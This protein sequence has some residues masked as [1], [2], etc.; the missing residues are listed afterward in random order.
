MAIRNFRPTSPGRRH[1]SVGTFTEVTTSEPER[2]LLTPLKKTAGRNSQGRVTARHRGGGHRRHYRIIDWKR[3]KDGIPA[4]VASIEYDPNR[5]A[6]IAL[7]HYADGEKRYILAPEGLKVGTEV[8]SG[9]EADIK[10]ANNLPL[11][12]IPIGTMVHNI[13]LYPGRGAQMVRA[14]GSA[15]QL[16]AK[17]SGKALLRLPS[18]E[19]RQVSHDCRASIG[20]VGNL[21]HENI[22]L[23]K[24]GRSRWK[25][26]RPRIRGVA[27]NPCDHP[28][29]GGEARS[30]PGRPSTTPWGK[31]AL[32]LKTRKKKASD[33]LIVR[34]RKK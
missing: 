15:A 12:K 27:T 8:H 33:A 29:G 5:T 31:P 24:A 4:K 30:T 9:E 22:S 13:E 10:P 18:G 32:G 7:L 34:R 25:G 19:V 14:A 16:M 17:D 23:G 28:H 11:R 2:S 1:M 21:N 6:F 3:T 26:I 20:Q